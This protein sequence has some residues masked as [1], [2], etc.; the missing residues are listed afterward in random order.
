MMENV[1]LYSLL[2]IIAVING[3]FR[4]KILVLILLLFLDTMGNKG[5]YIILNGKE[6][7]PNFEVYEAVPHPPGNLIILQKL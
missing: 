3:Y 4:F 5:A 7:K 1:L 6:M 2:L